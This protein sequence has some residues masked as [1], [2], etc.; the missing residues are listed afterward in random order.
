MTFGNNKKTSQSCETLRGFLVTFGDLAAWSKFFT[1]L[2]N[3][4]SDLFGLV[5]AGGTVI[6]HFAFFSVKCNAVM[7]YLSDIGISE[8][9]I[10]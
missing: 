1:K 7:I 8:V 9:I 5:T 6:R 10:I 2:M 3:A 4:R